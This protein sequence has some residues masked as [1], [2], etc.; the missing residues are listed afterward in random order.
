MR[1][2]EEPELRA[3]SDE[4]LL[5]DRY[6]VA[7]R[8]PGP[9]ADEQEAVTATPS[10]AVVRDTCRQLLGFSELEEQEEDEPKT[11]ETDRRIEEEHR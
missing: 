11:D 1:L 6:A 5:P 3:V 7:F 8:Y 4:L 10:A 2:G 9:N